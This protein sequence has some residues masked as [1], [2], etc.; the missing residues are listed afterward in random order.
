MDHQKKQLDSFYVMGISCRTINKNGQSGKDIS[1]L[2]DRFYKEDILSKIP[3]KVSNDVYNVYTDY[4]S[5]HNG[6][7]TTILGC[8]VKSLDAIHSGYTGK[9]IPAGHYNL[10]VSTGKL[11]NCVLKTWQDI[12]KS[13]IERVYIAD[14]DVYPESGDMDNAR[15]ETYLSVN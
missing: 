9:P 3:N 11:P 6:Y 4:E 7:Y 1:E 8:M 13:G 10:Y 15:V 2:W 5:D 14:F 12:W